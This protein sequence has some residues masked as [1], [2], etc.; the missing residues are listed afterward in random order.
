MKLRLIR[1]G[2]D[3]I[4]INLSFKYSTLN[5]KYED[6][7]KKLGILRQFIKSHVIIIIIILK[8][9]KHLLWNE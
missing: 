1:T 3:H 8:Q 6:F 9:I 4:T 7:T 2:F 5:F